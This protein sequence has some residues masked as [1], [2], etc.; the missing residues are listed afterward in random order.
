MTLYGEMALIL[1]YFTEFVSFR[2]AL[3]KNGLQ[4]HNYGQFMITMSRSRRLQ[5]NRAMPKV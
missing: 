5:K 2:G 3:R 1:R 4:S